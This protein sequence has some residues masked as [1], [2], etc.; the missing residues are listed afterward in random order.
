MDNVP[1]APIPGATMGPVFWDV[2]AF[3]DGPTLTLNGTIQEMH[4]QLL[5]INP[6]Y[7]A[8]F[9]RTAVATR[10]L[11]KR[12]DFTGS[13]VVCSQDLYGPIGEDPYH[14]GINYL[15]GHSGQPHLPPGP[16]ACGRVSCSYGTGIYIC[17]FTLEDKYLISWGSVADGAEYIWKECSDDSRETKIGGRA[18]H[19]TNWN[20]FIMSSR[21]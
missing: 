21:C 8:D 18:Y 12:T 13:Q 16:Q 6:D 5:E 10:D 7:D 2:Q 14:D 1:D 3:P 19:P 4:R 11:E 9:N 20:V 17:N 15:R